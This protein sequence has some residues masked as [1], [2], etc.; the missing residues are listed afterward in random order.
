[1]ELEEVNPENFEEYPIAE[2][3][4]DLCLNGELILVIDAIEENRLRR[5]LSVMKAKEAAKLKDNGLQPDDA[6]LE[7]ISI[8]DPKLP[9]EMKKL[10]I[11]LKGGKKIKIYQRVVPTEDLF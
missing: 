8:A 2:I 6:K 10:Q 1:M 4:K 3:Y 7:F 11:V 9:K 5:N